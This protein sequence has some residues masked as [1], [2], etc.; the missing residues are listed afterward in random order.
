M[1]YKPEL[2]HFVLYASYNY[3]VQPDE[4]KGTKVYNIKNATNTIRLNYNIQ[5]LSMKYIKSKDAFGIL[6]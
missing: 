3:N 5:E 6:S 4:S 2:C 1:Q